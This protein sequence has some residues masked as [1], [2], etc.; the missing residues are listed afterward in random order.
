M[1]RG[2]LR[3][4]RRGGVVVR[5]CRCRR[6][7]DD[8]IGLELI[9]VSFAGGCICS[10]LQSWVGLYIVLLMDGPLDC[11]QE[12]WPMA[13]GAVLGWLGSGVRLLKLL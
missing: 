12:A 4:E 10:T 2:R 6:S 5:R 8:W 3:L 9:W 11:V 7:S 13:N 1:A